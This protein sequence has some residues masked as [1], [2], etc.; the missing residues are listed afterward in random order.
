MWK[1]DL[2]DV[3]L[4]SV[5][6]LSYLKDTN[7]FFKDQ[8]DEEECRDKFIVISKYQ[9][10]TSKFEYEGLKTKEKTFWIWCFSQGKTYLIGDDS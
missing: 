2:D 5:I 10:I 8:N 3:H 9:I 4:I 7:I 6:I 1:N